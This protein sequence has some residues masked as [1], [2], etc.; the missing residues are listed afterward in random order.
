M[1]GR[2]LEAM[3]EWAQQPDIGCV[4]A[5]LLF[6]DGRLQ[7]VGVTLHD[8]SAFHPGYG[9]RPGAQNWLDVEV[10]RNYS[11]VTAAC[12]MMRRSVFEEVGGFDE[13]FP[14][15]YNDVDLCV[16]VGRRGYRHVYTPYARLYHHESSSRPPGVTIRE[17]DHLRSA[18]GSLLW[19]DP[20]AGAQPAVRVTPR[21]M[22]PMIGRLSRLARRGRDVASAV[23]WRRESLRGAEEISSEPP[24]S[25][26]IRWLDRVEV[27][28]QARIGLFMHPAASRTYRV[29]VSQGGRFVA[30][31]ALMPE[32]WDRNRGGVRFTVT[33]EVEGRSPRT[34]S[35]TIN[36]QGSV[37]HRAWR[38]VTVRLPRTKS[39]V[40]LTLRT[41]LPRGAAPA[42]AWAV[43]GDPLLLTPKP[44]GA[45]VRRQ[46]DLVRST[47]LRGA[48][49]WYARLLRGA[50]IDHAVYESWL[51][52]HRRPAADAGVTEQEIAALP[53]RPRISVVTPVYNTHPQWLR[54]CVQSTMDQTYPD[55]EHCL[56]DDGSTNPATVEALRE[57]ETSDPRVKVVHLAANGGISAA[58][59][60]ALALATGEFVALLDHDDELASDA[61]LEI[62][63]LLNDTPDADL[64]YTDED[65]LELDGTHAE[66]FFK[67]DWSPE[68]LHSTMYIGHLAV[69]RRSL[70]ESICGFRSEYDGSQD[71]DLALRATVGTDRVHH[72]PRVLYHWRKVPGSAAGVTDAKPWGLS[73]ARRALEDFSRTLPVPATVEDQ[74]GNGFWRLH[75]Q[76]VGD[77]LVSVMIPTDGRIAKTS[78]GERDLL[79]ECLRSIVSRTT[80]R[81]Y[82]LLVA[83][84]GRLS[85]QVLA[86]L[87][88][89]PHRRLVY[90]SDGPFNFAAKVNF[91]ARHAKGDHLL[92]LNDD[93][94]V[95]TPEWM[96]ALLEFSQQPAIGAVGGKLFYPDGRLQHVGVVLGI[97]GGAC[98]VLAGQPGRSPG[99]FGS[100]LVIRNYSAVTGACCMTRRAVFE[101][102]GGF[103]EHFAVDFNDVDYCLRAGAHGYRTVAT[104][105]A[106]MY[107][108]EGSTLAAGSTS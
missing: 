21:S 52:Q 17:N 64:I 105:F 11:A 63:R 73:A 58:S 24:G 42:S 88:D 85:P 50:P 96:S 93:T 92:L 53:W 9:E 32:V 80:Y 26:A 98:H 44:L 104:P 107:H 101:E 61:L 33:V 23:R 99:Y 103:D 22:P 40:T 8:G 48:L 102:L 95:L 15:A 87:R 55:W 91:V 39:G 13:T 70:I 54:A 74:P 68:Y 19:N 79:L 10:V 41:S 83:D 2:W 106:Q 28:Q 71:Y 37:R 108:F 57:L 59:N 49:R 82:E 75:F 47:G 31:L 7:H 78:R 100:A 51:R 67:P 81:N 72:I 20:Y 25:D 3:L 1:D 43:W 76:I 65:K 38:R 86:F 94:E 36:P 90:T 34:R 66:P 18:V 6:G 12:L 84:N 29:Q 30:W 45:I 60:A 97:G 69:Y 46:L 4:G 77:P 5:Q 62:V 35:W 14:V 89:V 27:A 16:R 56:A